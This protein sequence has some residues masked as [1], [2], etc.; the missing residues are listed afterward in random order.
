MRREKGSSSVPLLL[1]EL[2]LFVQC[3]PMTQH[4]ERANIVDLAQ[5]DKTSQYRASHHIVGELSC[6]SAAGLQS[7][8]LQS[9]QP[10]SGPRPVYDCLW[11][12]WPYASSLISNLD[13]TKPSNSVD[14]L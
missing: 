14:L 2:V 10:W 3:P 11:T 9:S 5:W 6:S 13:T 8:K 7:D 12:E 4:F 1:R